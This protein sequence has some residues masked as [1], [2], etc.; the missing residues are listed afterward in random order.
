MRYDRQRTH[1]RV[2]SNEAKTKKNRERGDDD[3]VTRTNAR[4]HA[5]FLV[6]VCQLTRTPQACGGLTRALS[7]LWSGLWTRYR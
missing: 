6:C 4:T 1:T 2:Q 5:T 7:S 3:F